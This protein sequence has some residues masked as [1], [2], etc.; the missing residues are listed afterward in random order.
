MST[1]HAVSDTPKLPLCR[2]RCVPEKSSVDRAGLLMKLSEGVSFQLIG[3]RDFG[4]ELAI[5]AGA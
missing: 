2:F 1:N 5:A 4:L 3:R